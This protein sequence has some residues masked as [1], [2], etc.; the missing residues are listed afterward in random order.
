MTEVGKFVSSLFTNLD[1]FLYGRVWEEINSKEI[2]QSLVDEFMEK[3][4]NSSSG[5]DRYFKFSQEEKHEGIKIGKDSMEA[6]FLKE[7]IVY[8]ILDPS[9]PAALTTNSLRQNHPK[10]YF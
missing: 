1:D 6:T 8:L 5:D 9:K 4:R 3:Y 2:S 10:I 7:S